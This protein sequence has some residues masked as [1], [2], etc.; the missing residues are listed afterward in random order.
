VTQHTIFN[1]TFVK[2]EIYEMSVERKQHTE[3]LTSSGASLLCYEYSRP[4]V[5][6]FC[7]TTFKLR[8][9]IRSET[10][11][12]VRNC[13]VIASCASYNLRSNICAENI[14][15]RVWKFHTQQQHEPGYMLS[16]PVS[17]K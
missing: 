14:G 5:A 13:A 2:T 15:W 6:G 11:T 9:I 10:Y 17:Y 8:N 3:N 16:E 7:Y 12:S 4:I 1:P